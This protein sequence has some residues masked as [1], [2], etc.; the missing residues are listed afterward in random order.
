MKGAQI[1]ATEAGNNWVGYMIDLVP[2]PILMVMPTDD[3]LKRNVKLRI[4]PMIEGT[5]RLIA[6]IGQARSKEGSN[7]AKQKLFP[8]GSLMMTG[9][10]SAAGLRS[11]P[12]RALMLDEVDAYPA[13]LDGE[14]DPI[15]LAQKRTATFPRRKIYI[16]S[17]PLTKG[18]SA[19]ED[20]FNDTDQNYWHVPCP[21]CGTFQKLVFE[22][23]RWEK[24]KPETVYY[25]CAECGDPIVEQ[26]HKTDMLEA[27]DFV[28]DFPEKS[29]PRKIGFHVGALY[30][31]VGWYSWEDA[32]R[33]WEDAQGKPEKLKSFVNT[34]LGQTYEEDGDAP[35]WERLMERAVDYPEN[36]PTKDVVFL[37]MGVDVQK[38]RL[39]LEIVGWQKGMI[40]QSV[41]FRVIMGDTTKSSTWDQ[42]ARVVNE[43]I[44]RED[45]LQMP[46]RITCVDTGYN[47]HYAYEFCRRFDPSRVIAIKGQESLQV[48]F[49]P[50]RTVDVRMDGKKTGRVKLLNLGVSLFKQRL[51]GYLRQTVDEDGR[52]PDGYCFFPK[53]D[54]SYFKG[55]TAERLTLVKDKKG[56]VKHVW[57]KTY[58][59]NEPL[60]V[61]V[62]A[63]AGATYIGVD[64]WSNENWDQIAASYSAAPKEQPIQRRKSEFWDR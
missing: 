41:S 47:T 48:P 64:R 15:K 30:S 3:T 27:G 39:E 22:Q 36:R 51:Y 56:Y 29:S 23:L 58:E 42:L 24:G 45:G 8:G 11:I 6:K 46:I 7:T 54:S 60:D 12:V 61:R 13:D 19:I 18:K 16:V 5:P 49:T 34:V 53:R 43:P 26:L 32:A 2:C 14:G 25:E 33:D 9:A 31:P 63:M 55:L 44:I 37:S 40:S 35:E 57:E 17:T 28:P 10:N 20:A 52:F 21:H 59:R 50:P 38:D 4:D 62:Y 1:G